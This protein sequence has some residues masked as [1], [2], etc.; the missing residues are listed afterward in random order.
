VAA[1]LKIRKTAIS[2]Q[3]NDRFWRN[4]VQWC[5]WALQTPSANK[6][7]W[8]RQSS[9][10]AAAILKNRKILIS[11]QLID[12]FWRS[13]ACWCVSTLSTPIDNKISLFQ[14]IEHGDGGHFENSKN[15][16]ISTTRLPILTTLSTTMS[17]G[18]PA[19][20]CQCNFPNLK[21]QDG[22][23]RHFKN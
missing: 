15:C 11:L 17:L 7:L 14:K 13:L 22:G 4:L 18:L 9:M 8:I 2:P 5:V 16:N 10:A 1:I 23:V 12:R 20:V 3:W 19:T 21:I 6:S